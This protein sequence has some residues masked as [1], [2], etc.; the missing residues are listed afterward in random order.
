MNPL[1]KLSDVLFSS[2]AHIWVAKLEVGERW[3]QVCMAEAGTFRTD[4]A[5]A[6]IAKLVDDCLND[7]PEL[8]PTARQVLDLL[9]ANKPKHLR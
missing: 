8:R 5:P 3:L 7:E 2:G 6:V 9:L 1:F 4:Q